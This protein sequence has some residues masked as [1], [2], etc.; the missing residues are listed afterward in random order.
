M[1]HLEVSRAQGGILL[2]DFLAE[3]FPGVN[4]AAL[5]RLIADGAVE[6]DGSEAKPGKRLRSGTLVMVDVDPAELAERPVATAEPVVLFENANLLVLDKPPGQPTIPDRQ[7]RTGIHG[8]LE[9][10]RPGADL[11]IV[12]RLDRDTSGCLL[13]AKGLD[14]ARHLDLQFRGGAVH[15]EYLALV[16][17]NVDRE[18]FTVELA[19]GPDP[20]RP[21]KVI[22]GDASKKGFRTARTDV[23]LERSFAGFSLL[24][25]RPRTGRGH[26]LRVHLASSGHPIA[27]DT[28][29][30]G[31]ELLLSRIKR[32]KKRVGTTE[33]PILTRMFLHAARVQLTDLDGT[34]VVVESPLPP[35]L[36]IVLDKLER[37]AKPRN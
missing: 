28:D 11:R 36:Q 2:A 37:F 8:S 25:L 23:A 31:E 7:G 6:V 29:Y 35:D 16:H 30:G 10:L 17:G 21:G 26:Q 3:S 9:E 18:T 27:A 1:K 32:Y 34:A 24:R 33:R 14:S 15:K 4:R 19:L 12:H 20:R 22:A 5:R 13:L